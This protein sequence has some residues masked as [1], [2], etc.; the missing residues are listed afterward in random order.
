MKYT[1]YGIAFGLLLV[2]T[3]VIVTFLVGYRPAPK[4]I[5][6]PSFFDKP[7]EIGVVTLKHFYAPLAD[8][9]VVVLGVPSNRD[10]AAPLVSGFMLAAQQNA[11][12]F[13]QVIVEQQLQDDLLAEIKKVV[14]TAKGIETN[15]ADLTALTEIVSKVQGSKPADSS[16]APTE[17]LLIV[18]P[19][20]YSTHLLAGNLVQ[21]LEASLAASS[22]S[23]SSD[24]ARP[25]R[26]L[27]SITVSPLALEP[28]QEKELDPI[29]IGSE[30]D[31]SG[32][33]DL[34]C[35]ILQAGRYF[36][37]KRIL[38]NEPRARERYIA[39]M[40]SQQPLDYMLM[41]REPRASR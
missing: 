21:R 37:R 1:K 19:N 41:V 15:S 6:K 5:M 12:A 31:G 14:P 23:G 7:E 30:R 35:A 9:S 39:I 40:Q 22:T 11:R 13:T 34:G 3:G 33:A 8:E 24:G 10:W 28:A 17:R 27:F 16:Q 20:L 32:T 29:C 25:P 36:Y 2:V 26:G 4:K 18:V 38:D